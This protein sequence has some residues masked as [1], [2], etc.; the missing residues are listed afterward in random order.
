MAARRSVFGRWSAFAGAGLAALVV[1]VAA[2]GGATDPGASV[3]SDRIA[4]ARVNGRIVLIDPSGRRLATLT[5]QPGRPDWAPA[6]SPDGT[7]IAFTRSTDGRGSFRIFVMRANGGG[8][9]R[10]TRGRF[11]DQAAWS[12]DGRWIAYASSP[13]DMANPAAVR[14]AGIRVV[15]PDGRGDHLVIGG[16]GSAFPSWTPDGR[17]AYA[18]HPEEPGS[19]PASCRRP[20]ARCGWVWAAR[21]DGTGR[22]PFVHGSPSRTASRC[23]TGMPQGGR[24]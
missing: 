22:R 4:V 18:L 1:M 2:I 20:R 12:P 19:W 17:L 21:A 5:S 9:R 23:A 7:R 10:L 15:R 24:Q 3:G 16:W 14:R 6:W 13:S 8:M 11:D